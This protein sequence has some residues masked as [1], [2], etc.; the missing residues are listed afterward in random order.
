VLTEE[1]MVPADRALDEAI[2]T[3]RWYR[4]LSGDARKRNRILDAIYKGA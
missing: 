4:R 3:F 2:R 1:E